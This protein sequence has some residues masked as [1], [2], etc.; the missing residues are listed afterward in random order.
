MTRLRAALV[1]LLDTVTVALQ[2]LLG[3]VRGPA[4]HILVTGPDSLGM[5]AITA[6]VAQSSSSLKVYSGRAKETSNSFRRAVISTSL[7]DLTDSTGVMATVGRFRRMVVVAATA[8]PRDM[9][10]AKDS[11]LP[12][13]WPDGFDYRFLFGPQGTK[14]F[15]EPGVLPRYAGLDEWKATA[16]ATVVTVSQ[17]EL[18]SDASAALARVAQS[19]PSGLRGLGRTLRSLGISLPKLLSWSDSKESTK[20]VVQQVTLAPGLETRAVELGYPALRTITK[21]R[22]PRVNRGTIVAFHT[23][24]EVYRAEAARLK[25]TLDALG[26]D[27]HFFE[28]TPEKN[29]VRTTLLKPSWILKARA[30]L[31]GPL[32]YID[33]DAYVHHDPW[34]LLSQCEGDLAAVVYRNGQLNSAT[35]W[36]NDTPGA[37]ALIAEW[38]DRAA[39]RRESDRGELEAT[40]DNGDQG[41]LKLAVLDDEAS[42]HPQFRFQRL[43]VNLAYIFD[44]TET[45]CVGPVVIEQLQVSRESA[46]HDKRL[47]RR[48]ERLL[49]LDRVEPSKARK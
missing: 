32:L 12:H 46:K 29:W 21:A 37:R 26:L 4:I 30:D 40:G 13:Q 23:P 11:R 35:I 8:D 48:K 20:R 34:P 17:E 1:K 44:R 7:D 24:D 2:R 18:S 25:K 41:V 38:N 22:A 5:Q 49:Q 31:K 14:S 33:V 15:T 28:V 42:A 3:A 39:N 43:P 47:A 27:Y 16:L 9:V 19:L 36:I 6:G 10:C 45:Y